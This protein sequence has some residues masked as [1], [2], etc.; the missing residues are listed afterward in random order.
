L[1]DVLYNIKIKTFV[2]N[3]ND[4]RVYPLDIIIF[5]RLKFVQRK[6]NPNY[7]VQG[8][9][10]YILIYLTIFSAEDPLNT[11][12]SNISSEKETFKTYFS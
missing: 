12:I 7:P 5:R 6:L 9:I 1:L 3:T 11:E 8:E 4:T 10:V 2:Q